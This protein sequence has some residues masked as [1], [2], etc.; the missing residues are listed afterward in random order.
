MK[1]PMIPTQLR[2]YVHIGL[3]VGM[4]IVIIG[5]VLFRDSEAA[6]QAVGLIGFAVGAAVYHFLDERNKARERREGKEP[7]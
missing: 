3:A 2:R 6:V 5:A 1:P 7:Q 4:T